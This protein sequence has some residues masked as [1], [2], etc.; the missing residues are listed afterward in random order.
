MSRPIMQAMSVSITLAAVTLAG[1]S[2]ASAQGF[3]LNPFTKKEPSPD[4][5]RRTVSDRPPE[6]PASSPFALPKFSLPTPKL[7]KISLPS[8]TLPGMGA[9]KNT[10][11]RKPSALENFNQGAKKLFG[12]TRD[13]VTSP[14]GTA[15]TP[16]TPV[17][18]TGSQPR[19]KKKQSNSSLFQLPSWLG[20]GPPPPPEPRTVQDFINQKRPGFDD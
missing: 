7:P 11:P 3:S 18:M 9:K 16:A 20:G 1:A 2:S 13:F 14:F 4:A 19:K 12:K 17:R 5:V 6:P 10:G 15:S 8:F